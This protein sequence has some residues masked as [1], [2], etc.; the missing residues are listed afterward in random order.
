MV[1]EHIDERVLVLAPTGRDAPLAVEVLAQAGVH[2]ISCKDM[3]ALC[4]RLHEGAG[5]ALIAEEALTSVASRCLIEALAHQPPWSDV[6]LVIVSGG[7][8]TPHASRLTLAAIA[9]LGNVTL[10]DRPL[11]MVAL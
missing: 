4:Q 3:D 6:P 8:A 10:L 1:N 11:G 5:A 2:A 7:E 9:P